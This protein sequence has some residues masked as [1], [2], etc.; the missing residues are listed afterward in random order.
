MKS[1]AA[2]LG[3]DLGFQQ[4]HVRAS[5]AA[6]GLEGSALDVE[7]LAGI[8]VGELP[9]VREPSDPKAEPVRASPPVVLN[10]RIESERDED[11]F[12]LAVNGGSRY[13]IEV[14]ASELGSALDG[15]LNV[16]NAKGES[17][18][19]AD[20]TNTPANQPK[21]IP[22]M[23]SPDP[24]L[25]YSVPSGQTEITLALKDLQGRGGVGF[26]YRITVTPVKPT[27]TVTLN[28]AQ[29]SLPK[30]GTAAV[31]VSLTRKGFNGP[32]TLKVENP[33]AGIIARPGLVAE[34]QAVGAFTVA[35]DA[36]L[37]PG[38]YRLD[39]VAEGAGPDGPIV[40]RASKT[41]VFASQA[42]MPTVSISERGL[43]AAPALEPPLKLD[44]PAEPV[45]VVHGH[46]APV[47]VKAV[48]KEGADLFRARVLVV[49][50]STAGKPL[51]L[52]KPI[53]A[54]FGAG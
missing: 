39:V 35:A 45:E 27:V 10:G 17:V 12:T 21:N 2:T 36:D 42:N 25:E 44:A 32:L 1:V 4:D 8:V 11:R 47:V 48:R 3:T 28:D 30:G 7:S 52:P 53:L 33:P 38:P 37:A 16:L 46:G 43:P 20:D 31:G 14:D 5:A 15:V 24:S 40:A 18:A 54:A 6:I 50:V 51:R 41:V 22:A 26:P 34:G 49:L 19:N 9:E 13:R 29:I 23:V